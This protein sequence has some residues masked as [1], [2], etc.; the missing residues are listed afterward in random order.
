MTRDEVT[1]KTRD[2][3]LVVLND[4][5]G[6]RVLDAAG[7]GGSALAVG[8]AEGRAEAVRSSGG[9]IRMTCVPSARVPEGNL[10]S[11]SGTVRLEGTWHSDWQKG[12]EMS[13]PLTLAAGGWRGCPPIS[14]SVH[15]PWNNVLSVTERQSTDRAAGAVGLAVGL[16]LLALGAVV[17]SSP[18]AD[19]QSCDWRGRC[20]TGT[21]LGIAMA[22]AGGLSALLGLAAVATPDQE[23]VIF[24]SAE[25]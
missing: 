15:T 2:P 24:G 22:I 1:V 4:A 10:V 6:A 25:D 20:F 7:T 18:H 3:H 14:G 12:Q 9:G 17:A 13:V 8:L 19:S 11:S 21:T 5:R 16:P 23:R